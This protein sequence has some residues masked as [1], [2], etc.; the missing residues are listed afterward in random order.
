MTEAILVTGGAGFIGSNFVMQWLARESAPVVNLDNLT[1]AGHLDSLPS[2][3]SNAKYQFFRG[4]V[5]DRE[6]VRRILSDSQPFA[7]VHFAAES[8]VDRSITGP[9]EFIRTN[10]HGTFTMLEEA[11]TYFDSLSPADQ[12]AIA[13]V[14]ALRDFAPFHQSAPIKPGFDANGRRLSEPGRNAC[15]SFADSRSEAGGP[16]RKLRM[17]HKTSDS[18]GAAMCCRSIQIDHAYCAQRNRSVGRS[19]RTAQNGRSWNESIWI[20]GFREHALRFPIR[21]ETLLTLRD[22][23]CRTRYC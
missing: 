18:R 6:L 8:H 15:H 16:P 5:N 1:Y 13:V 12:Q 9:E 19:N 20:V 11:R 23:N 3:A 21:A 14:I 17:T 2:I 22:R 10:I 4:D 7:I